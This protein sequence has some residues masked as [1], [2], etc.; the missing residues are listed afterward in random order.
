MLRQAQPLVLA[1]IAAALTSNDAVH[2]LNRL[3]ADIGA[4]RSLA[5]LGVTL[6]DL[7]TVTKVCAERSW[8]RPSLAEQAMP[9]VLAAALH[10][11]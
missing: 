11:S 3:A 8:G 4:P 2:G 7:R 10:H 6:N 9:D 5:E 1:S